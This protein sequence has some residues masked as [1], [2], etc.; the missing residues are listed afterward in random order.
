MEIHRD[1]FWGGRLT[2]WQPARRAGYR[3]NID[4]VLLASAVPSGDHAIDLGAGCG[5]LG[6]LLLAAKVVAA[7]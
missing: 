4:P 5:I 2:L 6:I 7:G 1:T 3:F